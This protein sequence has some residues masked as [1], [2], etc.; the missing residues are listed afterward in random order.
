MRALAR[1][2]SIVRV[3]GRARSRASCAVLYRKFVSWRLSGSCVS[4]PVDAG[5]VGVVV[6][7]PGL[8]LVVGCSGRCWPPSPDVLSPGPVCLGC[9][10]APW[11]RV[12][13]RKAPAGLLAR[14]PVPV[15]VRIPPRSFR[16]CGGLLGRLPGRRGAVGPGLVRL[17]RGS[18][19]CGF[20]PR[21]GEASG[22]RSLCVNISAPPGAVPFWLERWSWSAKGAESLRVSDSHQLPCLLATGGSDSEGVP[23]DEKASVLPFGVGPFCPVRAPP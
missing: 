20:L 17:S 3:R 14:F 18:G 7:V 12:R 16:G 8:G 22:G 2:W 1:A 13:V 5:V 21:M 19:G 4:G 23:V 9:A 6:A 11:A 10:R 15:G